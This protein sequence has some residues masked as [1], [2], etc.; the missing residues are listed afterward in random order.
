M[1]P[2]I[3]MMGLGVCLFSIYLLFSREKITAGDRIS[4]LILILWSLRFLLFYYKTH[5]DLSQYSWVIVADQN[6]FFLDGVFLYWLSKSINGEALSIWRKSFHL[7]PFIV[8]STASLSLYFSL[9]SSDLVKLYEDVNEK[10]VAKTFEPRLWEWVF[11]ISLVAINLIF[12]S[13]AIR[14]ARQ[15]NRSILNQFSDVGEIKAQW[16]EPVLIFCM[17]FLAIPLLLYFVNYVR[18]TL[19]VGWLGDL[20]LFFFS[21][22]AVVFSAYVARQS[23]APVPMVEEVEKRQLSKEREQKLQEGFQQLQA[24]MHATQAYLEPSLTLNKLAEQ[25]GLSA[26]QLSQVINTQTGGNFHDY[27]N[28]FRI[29]AIKKALVESDE[30][31]IVLAYTHGFNSKSTFN[32]VFK[33]IT[34][35][36]PTQYRKQ[37]KA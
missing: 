18:P 17:L 11:I 27:I 13:L 33:R 23:F 7:L 34:G 20:L 16:L 5:L 1:L 8:A 30:Q 21:L 2:D 35:L 32:D 37:T 29:E 25:V 14:K 28:Q 19:D 36:T 9:S 24:H 31:I 4:I 12:L 10:L 22:T 15:Y 26:N 6:L 3:Q